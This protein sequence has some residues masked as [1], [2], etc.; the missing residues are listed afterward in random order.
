MLDQFLTIVC[1]ERAEQLSGK[2]CAYVLRALVPFFSVSNEVQEA[3]ANLI[4]N[5]DAS[6]IST[7]KNEMDSDHVE[8]LSLYDNLPSPTQC[9][10]MH[11]L[12][13]TLF[14]T[15]PFQFL[16]FSNNISKLSKYLTN[17]NPKHR[18]VWFVNLGVLVAETI[19]TV[20]D[21][22]DLDKAMKYLVF[23]EDT[24]QPEEDSRCSAGDLA[25]PGVSAFLS[26]IA[27]PDNMDIIQTIKN[28]FYWKE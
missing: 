16:K 15:V 22:L 10:S 20:S 4:L 27:E 5:T 24:I 12:V 9:S 23:V 1:K 13:F 2:T 8:P 28:R 17:D 18:G 19:F 25:Y 7:F 21:S 6:Q 11:Q 26:K 14:S 3:C